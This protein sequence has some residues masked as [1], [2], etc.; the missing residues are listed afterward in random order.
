MAISIFVGR[1]P[2]DVAELRSE[3]S[4][5]RDD[6]NTLIARFRDAQI[7]KDTLRKQLTTL[8]MQIIERLSIFVGEESLKNIGNAK[9]AIPEDL[10]RWIPDDTKG[11]QEQTPLPN[12]PSQGHPKPLPRPA[13]DKIFSDRDD[14]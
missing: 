13:L 9:G 1:D 3:I 6:K 11:S 14:G 2:D 5:L 7:D 4:S 8:Q 12:H 10:A